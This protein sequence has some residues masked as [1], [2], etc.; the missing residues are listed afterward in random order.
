MERNRPPLLHPRIQIIL[1]SSSVF[2]KLAQWILPRMGCQ[3]VPRGGRWAR[4]QS[5]ATRSHVM[6]SCRRWEPSR[7]INS[8]QFM[9]NAMVMV[10]YATLRPSAASYMA[11]LFVMVIVPCLR[12]EG[13]LPSRRKQDQDCSAAVSV[14]FLRLWFS[15]VQ[16]RRLLK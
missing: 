14:V 1:S 2:E 13:L 16:T 6:G 3:W 7:A 12:S 9:L 15:L 8:T 4:T 11:W 10:S 5:T